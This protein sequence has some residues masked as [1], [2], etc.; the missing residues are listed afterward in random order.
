MDGDSW[1]KE[2]RIGKDVWKMISP[3]G[4]SVVVLKSGRRRGRNKHHVYVE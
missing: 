1:V 3:V 4:K 2:T